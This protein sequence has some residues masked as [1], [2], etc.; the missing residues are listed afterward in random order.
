MRLLIW[1]IVRLWFRHP[2]VFDAVMLFHMFSEVVFLS[3]L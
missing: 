2:P 3:I 1:L